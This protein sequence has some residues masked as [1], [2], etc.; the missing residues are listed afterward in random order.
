MTWKQIQ[1]RNTSKVRVN[2]VL[3]AEGEEKVLEFIL[4]WYSG[5]REGKN[6]VLKSLQGEFPEIE[7]IANSNKELFE[8]VK[9]PGTPTVYVNGYRF[10]RQYKVQ[11]IEYFTDEITSLTME[12]KGQEACSH[13]SE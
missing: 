11:D 5:S 4:G 2:I 7:K 1:H 10:P 8:R 3:S 9:I 13:C 12:S 6:V